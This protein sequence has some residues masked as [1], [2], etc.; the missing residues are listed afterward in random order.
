MG[1]YRTGTITL[2][3]GSDV[4]LGAGTAWVRNALPGDILSVPGAVL[5]VKRIVSD[6]EL[7]LATAYAGAGGVGLSYALV[8]TQGYVPD[9]L[10]AMQQILG[11]FGEIWQAWQA[12]DL[13]GRG[14]V[15]KGAEDAVEDLPLEGNTA[16]DGYIVAGSKLCVWNGTAWAYA[17]EMVTT[18]EMLQLRSDAV[19]ARDE[20][21]QGAV[22]ATAQAGIAVTAA[23]NVQTKARSVKLWT[24][25]AGLT[26]SVIGEGA[27]VWPSDPG[28]HVDPL[29][30]VPVSNAGSFSAYATTTGAWTR[31][32]DFGMASKAEKSL[33]DAIIALLAR[34]RQWVGS[35]IIPLL[36]DSSPTPTLLL[37][38]E[39]PENGGYLLARVRSTV[40][41]FRDGVMS[42]LGVPLSAVRSYTKNDGLFPCVADAGGNVLVGWNNNTKTPILANLA[43]ILPSSSAAITADWFA[44]VGYGQS[45]SVGSSAG[46]LSTSQP[47]ANITFGA[48][49]KASKA[50]SLGANPGTNTVKPLVEDALAADGIVGRGETFCSGAANDFTRR[51]LQRGFTVL[52]SIVF[53]S[54][55]GHGG[56]RVDQLDEASA[57]SQVFR[58]QITELKARADEAG[59]VARVVMIPYLQC[60]SD[61]DA[62]NEASTWKTRVLALQAYCEAFI[63]SVL[64]S[65]GRIPFAIYQT[66]YKSKGT[67]GAYLQAIFEMTRDYPDR[68]VFVSNIA[69]MPSADGTHMTAAGYQWW[70]RYVGRAMDQRVA[71]ETVRWLRPLSATTI[72]GVLIKVRFDVPTLPLRFDTVGV[73]A[74]TN[75]GIKVATD[76]GTQ[77]IA[78]MSLAGSELT[79]NLAA[80]LSGSNPVVRLGM[81]YWSGSDADAN[82]TTC[83]LRDSTLDAVSIDGVVR[84]CS[85]VVQAAQLSIATTIA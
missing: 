35:G 4:V 20:S 44:L 46:V 11:E 63:H 74:I 57:W 65:V 3:A 48:G 28:T 34:M 19:A 9:A 6:G 52:Q 51:R 12:G 73:G 84:D 82:R 22:T 83:N 32:A 7:Q 26:P 25:L 85:H 64:G 31:I 62:G 66:P 70:G 17:G 78:S 72:D 13:Q 59:R 76:A 15:L 29:T 50:G 42:A 55:A 53:A 40:G 18:T 49:P 60:E 61:M 75:N 1:W 77:A 36:T 10:Q 8:P 80:A 67:G 71:G 33:V 37:G 39:S 14:L 69:H 21:V 2:V 56:Y 54:T 30:G 81:D 24:T 79:I 16:G 5:E 27:E 58:D 43:A 68:F 47:F 23:E 45:L 41:W 38:I